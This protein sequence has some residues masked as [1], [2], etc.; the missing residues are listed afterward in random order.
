MNIRPISS[1]E[2][3]VYDALAAECGSIFHSSAWA[4]V[5]DG[6][7]VRHGMFTEAGEL[8]AGFCLQK[9]HMLGMSV[10]RMPP[11]TP[12]CGPFHR[13]QA[14]NPVAVLESRRK[15]LEAMAAFL[16]QR[17]HVLVALSLELAV[18]DMLPFYWRKFKV[19]PRYT[20]RIDLSVPMETIKDNMDSKRR[21]NI[22]KAVRDGLTVRPVTDMAIVRDLVLATFDRQNMRIH[23]VGIDRI[24]FQFA[25]PSNSYAYATYREE[26]PIACTFMVYDRT[27]AYYLLGGYR[28]E[29]QHPGAGP[30]AILAAIEHAKTQGL[31]TFDFEGS[32]VP[33]IEKYFRGFGGQLTPYFTVNKAW[34]P[35]E[36]LLQC[37]KRELF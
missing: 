13:I 33:A 28:K 1:A 29:E 12:Q 31:Q 15:I 34:L 30:L 10:L 14:R 16:D 17:S 36:M 11:F 24:L 9:R 25:Q 22:S 32:M 18:Q 8:V 26:T 21:S 4:R 20:Y 3:P 5:C 2:E 27:T 35:V 6:H 23:R 19:S 37:V 7:L